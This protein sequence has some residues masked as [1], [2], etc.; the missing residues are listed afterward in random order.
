MNISFSP[1]RRNQFFCLFDDQYM[2]LETPIFIHGAVFHQF[3][4][5]WYHWFI[6]TALKEVMEN[7]VGLNGLLFTYA[8]SAAGWWQPAKQSG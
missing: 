3:D 2:R 5:W 6:I 7:T 1:H 8:R 4:F